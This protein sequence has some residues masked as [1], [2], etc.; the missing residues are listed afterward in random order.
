MG[1]LVVT[2]TE[3]KGRHS[4]AW[5]PCAF[6]ILASLGLFAFYLGVITIAQDWDHAI[7]QLSDDRWFVSAIALGFGSQMGLFTYLRVLHANAASGGV[8]ASTGTSSVAMLA[9][10]A[11]HLTDV[12]PILGLSSVAIFLAAYKTP[13]L[14]LGIGMN[15]VGILYLLRKLRQVGL[16]IG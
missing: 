5:G 10:C 1:T 16:A 2:E 3:G 12:L 15:L 6:G 8:A 13:L 11:H 4:A 7:Q 14:W 9:C